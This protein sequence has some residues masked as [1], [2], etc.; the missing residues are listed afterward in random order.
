MEIVTVSKC[1]VCQEV[2][3]CATT[4]TKTYCRNCPSQFVNCLFSAGGNISH[5][6]C[7]KHL[8][9]ALKESRKRRGLV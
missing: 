8:E 7:P 4:S 5:G 3:A 2:F 9:I 6:Y 1:V